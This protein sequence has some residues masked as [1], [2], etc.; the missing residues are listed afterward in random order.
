MSVYIQYLKR[1]QIP[2]ALLTKMCGSCDIIAHW[3]AVSG[4]APFAFSV[5][6]TL[7]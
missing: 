6:N 3:S 2:N 5:A 4:P 7:F 1:L